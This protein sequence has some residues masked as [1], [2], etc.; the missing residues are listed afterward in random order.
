[1]KKLFSVSV[2]SVIILSTL[3]ARGLSTDLGL[4]LRKVS[5]SSGKSAMSS[6]LEVYMG[7]CSR[8]G[9]HFLSMKANEGLSQVTYLRSLGRFSYGSSFGQKTNAPF[10]APMLV[11]AHKGIALTSWNGIFLGHPEH[12]SCPKWKSRFAF[13]YHAVDVLVGNFGLGYSLLHYLK[14]EPMSL[15]Y[16]KWIWE[17]GKIGSSFSLTYNVRDKAPMFMVQGSYSL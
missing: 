17:L 8:D 15:P 9:E 7:F 6:G 14:Q 12:P 11:Y 13:S 10:I 1:M 3:F 16:I 2:V 4:A 5:I